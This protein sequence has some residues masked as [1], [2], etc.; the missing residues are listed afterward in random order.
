VKSTDARGTRLRVENA[1][2]GLAEAMQRLRSRQDVLDA[3][4]EV[5]GHALGVSR[6]V[7][8]EIDQAGAPEPVRHE[9]RS[10]S[11]KQAA[12]AALTGET[13]GRVASAV[14]GGEPM[15]IADSREQSL[16]GSLAAAELQV[17]SELAMP[18]KVEG[19]VRSI[20]YLHQCDRFR[21]WKRD[22]VE[23]AARVGRQLSLSLM[24]LTRL[25]DAARDAAKGAAH[26]AE[27]ERRLVRLDRRLPELEKVMAQTREAE[28]QARS[29]LALAKAAETEARGAAEAAARS[30]GEVRRERDQLREDEARV[31][32]SSQQLL[33]INRLK[34]DFITNAGRELEA[35]LQSLI[36]FVE[37][38]SQG[39]YGPLTDEQFEALRNIYSWARRLKSDVEQLID[40]GSSRARRLETG[41]E[42]TAGGD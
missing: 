35:S 37:Q 29:L 42:A 24:N 38:L 27:L 8:I 2:L 6:A 1:Y 32:R 15:E 34:S 28:E 3:V 40:Y 14:A 36:G 19:K 22:E 39:I 23:F 10:P 4:V 11:L 26:I 25:D 7:V 33:E 12:G 17:L 31:R 9:F 21:E 41:N 18:V 20:L 30:E 5:L 16:L 13:L